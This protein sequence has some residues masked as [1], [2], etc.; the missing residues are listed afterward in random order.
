MDAASRVI[1]FAAVLFLPLNALLDQQNSVDF[2]MIDV[3]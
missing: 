1:H 2:D 3:L